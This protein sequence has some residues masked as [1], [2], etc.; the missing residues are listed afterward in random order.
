MKNRKI[1][2][3]ISF[4]ATEASI[5]KL[6]KI[7][8]AAYLDWQL[9]PNQND[10]EILNQKIAN[11]RF[12]DDD[13]L[14]KGKKLRYIDAPIEKLW[15]IVINEARLG[16]EANIPALEVGITTILKEIYSQWQLQ[17]VMVNFWHNH[18]NVSVDADD[19]IAVTFP[20]YDKMIRKNCFGNFR[21]FLEEVAKSPAML[22]YLNNASSRAS[23]ANENYARELFELHTLGKQNYF[24]NLYDRWQEVPGAKEGKATGYIDEDIYETARAFTGWTVADGEWAE[25]GEKPHTGEF[26]YLE[27][28]HDNY[29]KRILATEFKSNQGQMEDAQKVLDLL[30][31]HAGTAHHLCSKLCIRLLGDNPPDSIIKKATKIWLAN[32]NAEDQIKQVVKAI[33]LSKEFEESLGKKIKNPLV[34]L[35]SMIKKMQLDFTPNSELIWMINRMGYYLFTW[36]T[37]TG[38]PESI[39]HWLGTDRLI[40]RWSIMPTILFNDWHKLTKFDIGQWIPSP[41]H[42]SKELV[43]YWATKILGKEHNL[44]AVQIEKLIKILLIE[45]KTADE[46]PFSYN[47][48]DRDY[49]FAHVISLLLMTPLFQYH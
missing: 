38:H 6:D 47:Q 46:P 41:Q 12:K 36:K 39:A 13:K 17:E 4:G 19:R 34:L 26:L 45:E 3:R 21:V 14:I 29:Q 5:N 20:L 42:T 24:N 8:L 22:Y 33:I 30:A 43:D 35:I 16:D 48:E 18:F 37:P 11:F 1:L 23:P 2:D 32:V 27:K 15:N 31:N 9:S 49:R 28:W 25:G 7:G 40:Q 44:P 10:T